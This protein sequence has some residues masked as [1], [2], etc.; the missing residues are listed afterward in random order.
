MEIHIFSYFLNKWEDKQ[1]QLRNVTSVI[2]YRRRDG[3][4]IGCR[5]LCFFLCLTKSNEHNL[6]IVQ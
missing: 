1:E 6:K 4:G 3:L 2:T 5:L